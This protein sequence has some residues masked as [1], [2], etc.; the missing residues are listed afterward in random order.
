MNLQQATSLLRR[1][2]PECEQPPADKTPWS[3]RREPGFHETTLDEYAVARCVAKLLIE[4]KDPRVQ[5]AFNL[6]ETI[7]A[8]GDTKVRDWVCGFLRALQDVAGWRASGYDAFVG[9]LQP[10]TRRAWFALEA[11]Q[12]DLADCSILEEEITMWRVV[13]HAACSSQA[14]R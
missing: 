13:H 14:C 4:R 9:F 2:C 7:L 3:A 8:S 5:H 6:M 1:E 12:T 10:E 11:I